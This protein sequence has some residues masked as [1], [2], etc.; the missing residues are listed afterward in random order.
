[1]R[2]RLGITC[3]T[4]SN[5]TIV[6]ADINKNAPNYISHSVSSPPQYLVLF[7]EALTI[8]GLRASFYVHI[9]QLSSFKAPTLWF[10]DLTVATYHMHLQCTFLSLWVYANFFHEETDKTRKYLK[11]AIFVWYE[12]G[13]Q[14]LLGAQSINSERASCW[15]CCLFTW[16]E[17][18]GL[19]ETIHSN[20]V[21]LVWITSIP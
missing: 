16:Y 20:Y 18:K 12:N 6:V 10:I 14:R 11:S 21:C 8:N 19:A 9:R 13:R 7:K 4:K 2:R 1:M 15:E 5:W 3:H 17:M